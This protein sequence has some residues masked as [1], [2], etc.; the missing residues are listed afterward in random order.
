VERNV[1]DVAG[2]RADADLFR[3]LPHE[4]VAGIFAVFDL[5][6]R[7]LPGAREM[8]A[9]LSLCNQ[10]LPVPNDDPGRDEECGHGG[11]LTLDAPRKGR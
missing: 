9:C 6:A 8:R 11:I 1:E 10:D 4:G 5:A 2:D 3:E 7:K